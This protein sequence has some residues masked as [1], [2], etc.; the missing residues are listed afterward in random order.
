MPSG[1]ID[2]VAK[3]IEL[4]KKGAD[5]SLNAEPFYRKAFSLYVESPVLL[6]EEIVRWPTEL[7]DDQRSALEKWVETNSEALAQLRLGTQRPSY[8]FQYQGTHVLAKDRLRDMPKVRLLLWA[9]GVRAKFKAANGNTTGAVDDLLVSFRFAADMR[10]RPLWGEQLGGIWGSV[11]ALRTQFLILN[12]SQLDPALMKSVQSRLT[13]LSR[14]RAWFVDLRAGEF[15]V[16]EA[17]QGLYAQWPGS[18]GKENARVLDEAISSM[19]SARM[20]ADYGVDLNAEQVYSSVYRYTPEAMASLIRRAFTYYSSIASKTP[21]QWHQER[22][23]GD[24][25]MRESVNGNPLLLK[26]VPYVPDVSKVSSRCR[27]ERD[28][29]ITTLALLRHKND[30]GGFPTDLEELVSAGYLP[31]LPMDPYS[32][33]PLV[34]RRTEGGFTL[35]S[36]GADFKDNGGVHSPKWVR[37][38]RGE[39]SSSGRCRVSEPESTRCMQMSCGGLRMTGYLAIQMM[40]LS[41][42]AGLGEG[43]G[44]DDLPRLLAGRTRAENALWIENP[45]TARFNSSKQVM[46]AEIKGPAVITMIHFAMPQALKLNRDLLLKVYWDGETS[47]SVDCP[48]VDFFCDPAGLREEVNTSLVNKR[49]GF[50]AYFPM[51]FRT[52]AKI[53]LVYDGPMSPGTGV[54][55]GH[56]VLQ[57]RHVPDCSRRFRQTAATSMP[58]GGRRVCCWA[59]AITSRWRPRARANSS[60]GT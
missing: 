29:L 23:N 20:K 46:V 30:K 58:I 2:Y 7:T 5:E 21:Y 16:L 28:G 27:A 19:L 11:F 37:R 14:D 34:Y 15:E 10:K 36:V 57:L 3:L 60:A 6:G 55:E 49:R 48:L 32:E 59:R 45:L 50:N 39:T 38:H 22:I 40:A 4:V 41:L 18:G 47:P 42:V 35:Y 44:I 26:L 53:E 1:K 31:E 51:P 52:S 17:M 13:E 56:A 33:W 9:L 54:V 24:E 43:A 8:W 12:R 25:A